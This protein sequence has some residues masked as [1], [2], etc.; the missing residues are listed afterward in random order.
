MRDVKLFSKINEEKGYQRRI[1]TG[2]NKLLSN[3]GKG[4]NHESGEAPRR[5][6]GTR[7]D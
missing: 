4:Q 2:K 3:K 1:E 6:D 7:S 5:L